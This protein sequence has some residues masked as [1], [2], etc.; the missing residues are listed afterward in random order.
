[1]TGLI[2]AYT[3]GYIHLSSIVITSTYS[4][5]NDPTT[6]HTFMTKYIGKLNRQMTRHTTQVGMTNTCSM[7]LDLQLI[8]LKRIQRDSSEL[9]LSPGGL[10]D[11]CTSSGHYANVEVLSRR[12]FLF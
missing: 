12:S 9:G 6:S 8:G 10:N 4:A 5:L 11:Q 3:D 1:M 2:E 7:L